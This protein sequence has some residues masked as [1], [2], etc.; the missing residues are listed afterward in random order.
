MNFLS[1]TSS[2]T[3]L[4]QKSRKEKKKQAGLKKGFGKI[5][6]EPKYFQSE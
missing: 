6:E 1:G 4:K 3:F 5:E 2:Y